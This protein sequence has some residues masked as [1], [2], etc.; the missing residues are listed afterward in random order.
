[1]A[2]QQA[3]GI[4]KSPVIYPHNAFSEATMRIKHVISPALA[5]GDVLEIACLPAHTMLTDVQVSSTGI[6]EVATLQV[7]TLSGDYGVIV[8]ERTLE[9]EMALDAVPKNAAQT[10]TLASLDAMIPADRHRGIG[11]KAS[12]AV[13]AGT[14]TIQYS[15]MAV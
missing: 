1:M 15:F 12:A 13:A 4:N 11:I 9:T 14:I 5:S 7:G 6:A 3:K 10:A 2:T 8:G